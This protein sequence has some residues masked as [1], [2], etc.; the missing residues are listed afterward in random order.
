MANASEK[1]IK[2]RLNRTTRLE[3]K[4]AFHAGRAAIPD[5]IL[6]KCFMGSSPSV[7]QAWNSR[8]P[9]QAWLSNML[10]VFAISAPTAG[11]MHNVSGK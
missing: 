11:K 4:F 10:A 9:N 6:S 5:N 7:F 2:S 1:L 8:P 3:D